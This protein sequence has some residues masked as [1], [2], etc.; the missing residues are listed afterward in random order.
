MASTLMFYLLLLNSFRFL[1]SKNPRYLPAGG[2]YMSH[3]FPS[4]FTLHSS[5]FTLQHSHFTYLSLS[6]NT[7]LNFSSLGTI[8]NVQ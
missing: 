5:L 2:I 7:F 6:L 1:V 3:T 4:L 8:T